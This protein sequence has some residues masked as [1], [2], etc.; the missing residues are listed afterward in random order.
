MH[1]RISF[2]FALCALSA[3]V[4][5]GKDDRPADDGIERVVLGAS[6]LEMKLPEGMDGRPQRAGA[7]V[8]AA[9]RGDGERPR[10]SVVVTLEAGDADPSAPAWREQYRETLASMLEEFEVLASGEQTFA[11]VPGWSIETR[12]LA[13][14]HR[15]H[16]LQVLVG[17]SPARFLTF[18]AR[19]DA[20]EQVRPEIEASLATL[21]PASSP[22]DASPAMPGPLPWAA[23]SAMAPPPAIVEGRCVVPEHGV[24]LTLPD[25]FEPGPPPMR[26]ALLFATG[27]T[28]GAFTPNLN[29]MLSEGRPDF[30]A[31]DIEPTI[32]EG[33]TS[34]MRD[35]EVQ[36][37]EDVRIAGR[38]AVRAR[39]TWRFVP[40]GGAGGEDQT[41]HV[42]Q[43]LFSHPRGAYVLTYSLPESLGEDERARIEKSVESIEFEAKDG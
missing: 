33:M 41:I 6:G 37:V 39:A 22:P 27:P 30:R 38:A 25:G 18:V 23:G 17:G 1:D 12:F 31:M 4:A 5:C 14:E 24:S 29:L 8:F 32:R 34:S 40:G 20:F 26:E 11:G 3:L 15:M 7:M 21:R 2:A 35:A 28:H 10:M 16:N 9:A 36:V 19:D 43:Y 13:N 42:A